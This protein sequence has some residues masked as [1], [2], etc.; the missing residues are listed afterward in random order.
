MPLT[1]THCHLDF[2]WFDTDRDLV[3]ERALAAGLER[4][5][6]P[7]IDFESSRKALRLADAYTI[8]RVAVGFHPNDAEKWDVSSLAAIRELAAHPAV[9]AIGEI[10]LDYY[11]NRASRERQ[12]QVFREQLDL[13]AELALPVIVHCRDASSDTL[14]ILCAWQEELARAAHPLADKPGVLHAFSGSLEDALRMMQYHFFLG[15]DGPLTYK[16]AEGLRSIIAA[17]P[18][19]SLLVETDSPFLTPH[20][21]RG[22]RNEPENVKYVV[23]KLAA[24]SNLPGSTVE[25]KT[26]ANAGRIFQW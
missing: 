18:L 17:V 1:D 4:L 7:G 2:E 9:V 22:S 8:V 26:T 23:E 24:I 13:A 15:V 6:N 3:V 16:N 20:P 5:L 19:D 14:Q 11:R 10:G 21:F 25:E 12:I